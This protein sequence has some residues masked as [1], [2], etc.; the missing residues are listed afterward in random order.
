MLLAALVLLLAGAERAGATH[1]LVVTPLSDSN[2]VGTTHTFTATIAPVSPSQLL[3]FSI[4]AGPNSGDGGAVFTN[5]QGVAT[6]SYV[7]DGGQGTDAILVWVDEDVDGVID[8]GETLGGASKTWTATPGPAD[9]ITLTPLS[10]TNP[11]GTSH[12]LTATVSPA[13]DGI[14]VRFEVLSGPNAGDKRSDET[15]GSGV[16]TASY[17]GDGGTGVDTILAWADLD[18][19]GNLDSGEPA[20]VAT[21]TWIA[22]TSVRI[23]TLL[24]LSDT[25]L[26]GTRHLL[27]ATVSPVQRDVRVRFEVISGPNAGD[28]FS[29]RTNSSG[30]ASQDYLGDGGAG[31]DLIFAWADLDDDGVR[32]SSEPTLSATK[33]WTTSG[34]V[35]TVTLT[36]VTDTN[37]VGTSHR[38]TATLFPA[39]SNSTVRLEVLSGPN[40]GVERSDLTNSSGVAVV[41]YLGDGGAG[42]DTIVAWADLDRDGRRDG[43]EPFDL[44][45]KTW[46]GAGP[47]TSIALTPASDSNLVG[48]TH[49][50]TATVSPARSGVTVRFEVFTGPNDGTRR[51]DGTNSSGVATVSYR[52]SG[53]VGSDTILAWADLDGDGQ[54]DAGEPAALASKTWTIAEVLGTFLQGTVPRIGAALI[55]WGGGDGD[56][57]LSASNCGSLTSRARFWVSQVTAGHGEFIVYIPAT[58]VGAVN[59]RWFAR[60]P[61]GFVPSGTVL[62]ATCGG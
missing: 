56:L 25:N 28:K 33:T 29:D 57:L 18:R 38:L 2:P 61:G 51:S 5:A 15:N 32:D 37:P 41:D 49:G 58:S 54:R 14:L 13:D 17:T 1:T 8:G 45:T 6:F 47:V 62:L 50:L 9:A 39:Q 23:V 36:P 46:T 22:A 31:T 42:T 30:V 11:L 24:P 55:I 19:D 59:A 4:V 43:N 34:G 52:G 10:D 60:F 26:V 53:G 40:A 7:G 20:V 16:A 44:A 3:R 27:T 48:T 12:Q 35:L 21:K